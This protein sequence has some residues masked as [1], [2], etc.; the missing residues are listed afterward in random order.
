MN[1]KSKM[2]TVQLRVCLSISCC[3]LLAV[4]FV[5]AEGFAQDAIYQYRSN[6]RASKVSGKIT[7]VSPDG[8]K[9]DGKLIPAAEIKRLSFAKEPSEVNRAREQMDAGRFSDALEDLLQT[10]IQ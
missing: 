6:G 8:A 7:D 1:L 4:L 10:C 2:F 5:P 9:V 3:A